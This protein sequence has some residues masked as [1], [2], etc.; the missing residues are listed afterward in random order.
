MCGIFSILNYNG[1]TT[2][3]ENELNS[4]RETLNTKQ[5]FINS[6]ND[7]ITVYKNKFATLPSLFKK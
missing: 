5:N 3:L 2:E 7:S 4:K 1:D 6:I